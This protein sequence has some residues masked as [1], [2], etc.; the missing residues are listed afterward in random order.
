MYY[1]LFNFRYKILTDGL[2]INKDDFNKIDSFP[3][4]RMG[5]FLII[6]I[7]SRLFTIQLLETT[8]QQ[9]TFSRT[10]KA[11]IHVSDELENAE[12]NYRLASYYYQTYQPLVAIQSANEAKA[13]FSKHI[14]CE[15]NVAL[16]DNIF[17]FILY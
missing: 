4:Q 17:G 9:N 8:I 14:N 15:I 13:I 3:L 7:F 16:C 11:L 2:N 5:Y 1:S 12:F 10:L 6:I